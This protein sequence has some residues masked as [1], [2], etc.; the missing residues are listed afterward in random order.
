MFRLPVCPHCCTVYRYGDV[1]RVTYRREQVCYHCKKTMRVSRRGWWLLAAIAVVLSVLSNILVMNLVPNATY[2]T[3]YL[4]TVCWIV[5]AYFMRPF[6]T[7][8]KSN[9]PKKR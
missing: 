4:V 1:R 3:M 5:A 9:E 7:Q 6:F 2:L 8:F